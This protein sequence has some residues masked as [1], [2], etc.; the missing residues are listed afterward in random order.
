MK[1]LILSVLIFTTFVL[2]GQ[3][4][5]YTK[6]QAKILS[7]SEMLGRGYVKKGANKA[8]KHIASEFKSIGL[9]FFNGSPYQDFTYA[10]N[11]FP[12][13]QSVSIN[14][15]VLEAGKDFLISPESGTDKVSAKVLKIDKSDI[16]KLPNPKDLGNRI[17]VLD[18]NGIQDK[19]SLGLFFQLRELYAE[20]LPVIWVN[21]NRL[22]WS[23]ARR[24]MNHSI[25]EV[26]LKLRI[27]GSQISKPKMSWVL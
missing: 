24:K 13:K 8:A 10:V 21:N 1:S 25:V 3:D 27:S 22:I 15:K 23:V 12:Q 26:N 5:E 18:D 6:T 19:D 16:D 9:E 7:S 17:I 20:H 2:T 14:G 11:S 4:L